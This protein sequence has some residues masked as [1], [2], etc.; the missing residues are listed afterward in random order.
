MR[1][2]VTGAT[3]SLGSA[4]VR[5]LAHRDGRIR[6]FVRDEASFERRFPDLP[7]ERVVGDALVPADVRRA[8]ADCDVVFHCV[9]FPLTRFELSVDAA[10]VLVK[11][12]EAGTHVV[13]PGNTW[14]FGEPESLPIT[15]ETPYDPPS[16]IAEFKADVVEVLERSALPTTVVHLPD[17]YGPAVDN[18]VTRRLFEP[19]IEG[20]DARFPAP[21]DV[22]HEF[23][24][25]DDAARAMVDVAGESVAM[26]RRYTVGATRPITVR[27]FAALVYE[28]AGTTGEV[29]SLPDWMLRV[30]G[31]VSD[32]ARAGSDVMDVFRHD[33]R[34]DGSAILAD[35][36]FS[37][38]V[39]YEEGIERTVAW[40][41]EREEAPVEH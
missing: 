35:V 33:V 40:Y 32:E 22:P 18:P 39:D 2:L 14:V 36:G 29:R 19:A 25:V 6:T 30:V 21:A 4:V 26:D 37:P 11:A 24:F 3:G 5:Q 15:P 31:L 23:I 7:A 8:A 12:A 9:G 27:E 16:R 1:Y 34:M 38:R 13:Y 28:A 41:R 10:E 20:Q 17:F